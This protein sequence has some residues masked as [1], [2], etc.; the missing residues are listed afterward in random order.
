MVREM[1]R[2]FFLSAYKAFPVWLMMCQ[3]TQIVDIKVAVTNSF[4]LAPHPCI[5]RDT[6]YLTTI[7]T[8]GC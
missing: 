5:E 8:E 2:L 7:K 4:P 3:L 6:N 1:L